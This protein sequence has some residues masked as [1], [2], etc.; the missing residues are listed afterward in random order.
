[1]TLKF[2]KQRLELA[3]SILVITL[4]PLM[5]IGSTLWLTSQ[6]KQNFDLEL[7]RKANLAN[8]VFGISVANIISSN[9]PTQSASSIQ[10][11][12]DQTLPE[13]PEI[14]QL[15]VSILS[16]NTLTTIASSDPSKNGL[17]DTT[18][19]SKFAWSKQQSI[20]SLI[21]AGEG[22]TRDWLVATPIF[23]ATGQEVA[24]SSLRVSLANSDSIMASTLRDSYII[25]GLILIV[26]IAL[27]LDHFKFIQ[28]SE[29]FR[30]QKELDQMKDDFINI[31]THELRAPMGIIKGYISLALEEPV[32]EVVK[33]QLNVAFDQTDRLGHLIGDLLDVSRLEQNKTSFDLKLVSLA[34]I[35]GPLV[36]TFGVKASEKGLKLVHQENLSLP[37]VLGDADRITEVFTNLIDNA[38][39]YSRQGSIIISYEINSQSVIAKVSDTGIGMTLEEQGR[40]FQ[41]FYRAKNQDT[42]GISGTG[43]GLWIIKQ[44]VERMGGTIKVNSEKGKGSTFEVILPVA[45]PKIETSKILA[46]NS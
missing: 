9:S 2:D 46:K 6:L 11:L 15:S 44:Y 7:Q 22:G 43:L 28:Y 38:I 5:V 10:S 14:D 25:L 20:A 19:Q 41:R 34:P 29:L 26:I 8:E 30:K 31:A 13:A 27:L 40:L 37:M 21:V 33:T 42:A 32:G 35:I 18:I 24:I 4:I 17:P 3:Y 45:S 1:M 23:N 39:K 16:N 36:T 12:I